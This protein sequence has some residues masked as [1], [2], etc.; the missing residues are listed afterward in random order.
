MIVNRTAMPAVNENDTED[1]G[2]GQNYN[3]KKMNIRC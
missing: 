1:V 2:S 3:D